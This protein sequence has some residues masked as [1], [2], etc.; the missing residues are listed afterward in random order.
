MP[1]LSSIHWDESTGACTKHGH[2]EVPCPQ[3][4]VEHDEEIEVRLDEV[5]KIDP[6]ALARIPEWMRERIV[7]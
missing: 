6:E 5:E 4:I 2:P 3:C 1:K 7:V